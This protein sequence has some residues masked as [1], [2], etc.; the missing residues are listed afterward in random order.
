MG[1][2][3]KS[4]IRMLW[5]LIATVRVLVFPTI[6]RYIQIEIIHWQLVCA[7]AVIVVIVVVVILVVVVIFMVASSTI[8][9]TGIGGGRSVCPLLEIWYKLWML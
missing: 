4:S 6:K 3:I 7:V 9:A 1:P 2:I 5:R 8:L